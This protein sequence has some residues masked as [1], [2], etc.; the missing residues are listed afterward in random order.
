MV[1]VTIKAQLHG[2]EY[3]SNFILNFDLY[4]LKSFD[5]LK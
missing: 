3:I 5:Y 2:K 1:A 4:Q